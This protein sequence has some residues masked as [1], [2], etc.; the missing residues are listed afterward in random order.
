MID[1]RLP[2]S[3]NNSADSRIRG[4]DEMTDALNIL[5]TGESG[6]GAD[7]GIT[8]D[9]G[10]VKPVNGNIVAPNV[11]D[12]FN[13]NYE[14]VV[15]G[16]VEDSKY[17]Y[18][19]FFL[20]SELASEMGV[21]R[22]T[23]GLNVERVYSSA[24][25]NFQSDGFV[26]ADIT[27]LN[28][29]NVDEPERTI[30]YFTDNVNEPR[31][32]D[33][34]RVMAAG[35]GAGYD[36]YDIVDTICACPRHPALP[37][38]AAFNF[39][40]E[41]DFKNFND[42]PGF[43][44]AYQNIYY[45]GEESAISTY[46]AFAIPAAYLSS[47]TNIVQSGEVENRC[48]I[49]VPRDGYTREIET[50]RI[51]GKEADSPN[52]YIID[53]VEPNYDGD[54]QYDFYNDRILVAVPEYEVSKQFDNLPKRAQAQTVSENRLFYGNYVEGF[55][56]IQTNVDVTAVYQQRGQDFVNSSISIESVLSVVGRDSNSGPRNR[57]VSFKIGEPNIPDLMEAGDTYRVLFS[58]TPSNNWHIYN[59]RNSFHA[60]NYD[61]VEPPSNE[62]GLDSSGLSDDYSITRNSYGEL[63][64]QDLDLFT[65]DGEYNSSWKTLIGSDP[66]STSVGYGT[67]P[68]T[69]IIIR[70]GA[71]TFDVHI[72]AT[73]NITSAPNAV[74]SNI[75]KA[76][77][78]EDLD[79]EFEFVTDPKIT[80]DYNFDL[81][82]G[83][84]QQIFPNTTLSDL[85][86]CAVDAND[87]ASTNS[88]SIGKPPIG[89]F[90]VNS[91]DINF[92]LRNLSGQGYEDVVS[93]DLAS[94]NNVDSVTV[95]PDVSVGD[96]D[97]TQGGNPNNN[98][99]YQW[100]GPTDIP[101]IV[102]W[103][104]VRSE[105]ESDF[106]S[107]L[108]NA[109]LVNDNIA[110]S[111]VWISSVVSSNFSLDDPDAANR[112]NKTL[113]YLISGG[114]KI[115][116][117]LDE[118]GLDYNEHAFS[119]IDGQAG[120]GGQDLNY[121]DTTYDYIGDFSVSD[122]VFRLGR[123]IS[124][125][126]RNIPLMTIET[127]F[128]INLEL[129]TDPLPLWLTNAASIVKASISQV[130]SYQ[131]VVNNS[132]FSRSFKTDSIHSFGI[133][134]YDQRGRAS[135]VM[136]IGSVYINGLG[137][138][139]NITET[140][141]SGVNISLNYNPP[142]W[143]YHYQI[144]YTGNNTISNFIQYTSAGAFRDSESNRIYVSL[145][146]LQE[147]NVSYAEEFGAKTPLGDD[148]LYTYQEG[149]KLRVIS[150]YRDGDGSREF[151]ND[152]E[153]DIVDFVTLTNDESTNP[154]YEEGENLTDGNQIKVGDFIVL[155][156][157]PNNVD[158]SAA[159][160]ANGADLWNNRCVVELFSRKK[161]QDEEDIAYFETSDVYDVVINTQGVLVHDVPNIT[162]YNGDVF[163]R[164]V[165]VKMP[166]YIT[167][168][169]SDTFPN[170][171]IGTY[172]DMI[173]S[174]NSNFSSYFLETETFNDLIRFSDVDNF[175][176][177]K[178]IL[179]ND[180]EVRRTSSIS[181]GEAN[182]YASSLSKFTSFNKSIGNYKDIPNGYGSINYIQAFNEF[183]I[184]I[185]ESKISRIPVNRNIISDASTNQQ[186]I[187]TLQV[188]G[189]QAFFNG[190]YGCDGHPE[191][192]VVDDNDVYFADRGSEQIIMFNRYQGGVTPISD[193]GMKEFFE[194]QFRALGDNPRIVGG[195]D[196]L[197]GE[198]IISMY[199]QDQVNAQGLAFVSQPNQ[200]VPEDDGGGGGVV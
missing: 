53:E 162:T 69:P 197:N 136:P 94:V 75:C 33:V 193:Q 153:F 178:A 71:L 182:N 125:G 121:D 145:N 185:Q 196:P 22:T 133:V 34:N 155:K 17:G 76:L 169:N 127:P 29:Q 163:F 149:D 195:F 118:K 139:G 140:G 50:I 124:G 199:D 16:S 6:A 189:V 12:L 114:N 36:Q 126:K 91:A 120:P 95:I 116:Y 47:G 165:P 117:S 175:G 192:V 64:G 30:L 112:I 147:R 84:N 20:F 134:Y 184:C 9:S 7:G 171:E 187:A 156:N 200:Q 179:P 82:I 1:K 39:D 72:R 180:I 43:Q 106:I 21:Y 198:F 122:S 19:Y 138:R 49:V 87:L 4:V 88:D 130:V 65:F 24:Y 31:K 83:T 28:S 152:I 73:Q 51:L 26:K 59:S 54:T 104:A 160:V 123:N 191:S 157:N 32:L 68:T 107:F 85:I 173:K 177:V 128:G 62:V 170:Q 11:E 132:S 92:R 101:E 79:T 8:G 190:D 174:G 14:K 166:T 25:F 137:N 3:L 172:E 186:L 194:R 143:A 108:S 90:I 45:S 142:E 80:S 110:N 60:F 99:I 146:Y 44:F 176:K 109:N 113:G 56:P 42:R 141:A 74:R 61:F 100:P 66:V 167:D 2:R 18:V 57:S 97:N 77:G 10:V 70:G 13:P 129:T 41:S 48:Q 131:T 37:P 86:C 38:T 58:V 161:R 188:L 52:W 96:L 135:N 63:L 168:Q 78:G 98:P 67:S 119:I 105:S 151:F 103:V 55:N 89:Y 158:F 154:L 5:V 164:R 35:F 111:L 102:K 93:L 181:F 81:G 150:A 115:I 46:S 144:V 27:H 183:L 40:P 15:I 159:A 148:K 23:P